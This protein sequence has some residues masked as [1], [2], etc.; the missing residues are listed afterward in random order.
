MCSAQN[1]IECS[2]PECPR[3]MVTKSCNTEHMYSLNA[4]PSGLLSILRRRHGGARR[5]RPER[6]ACQ[7]RKEV[8]LALL[9]SCKTLSSTHSRRTNS[10]Q[11]RKPQ[12]KV[13]SLNYLKQFEQIYPYPSQIRPFP[14]DLLPTQWKIKQTSR[15]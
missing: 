9:P 2:W 4:Y 7:F 11:T 10:S 13:I 5:R 15:W 1:V 14:T 3:R 6:F 12:Q 8:L